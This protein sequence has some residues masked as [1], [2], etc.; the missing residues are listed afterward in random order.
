MK[1]PKSYTENR[2]SCFN[3]KHCRKFDGY[4]DGLLSFCSQD[5]EEAPVYPLSSTGLSM[6]IGS[7]ERRE[8]R[9]KWNEWSREREVELFGVC[10]EHEE[11]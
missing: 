4:E 6:K 9:D 8:M 5:G 2:K 11:E 1:V 10:D 7:Q 3:C